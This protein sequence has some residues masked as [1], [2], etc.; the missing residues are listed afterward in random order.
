MN[1]VDNYLLQVEG[2]KKYFL[3]Y[4]QE[5]IIRK[6]NLEA[7]ENYLYPE[8]LGRS[9]RIHRHSGMVERLEEKW[10]ETNAHGEVMTLL[11]LVCDSRED[12]FP[13][14]RWQAM[15]NFGSMFHRSLLEERED[16]FARA[17]QENPQGFCRACEALGGEPGPSGDISY[18]LE[19]FDGLKVLAQFWEEDEDFPPQVRWMWDAN[20]LMYLKYETMWYALGMLQREILLRM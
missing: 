3:R 18:T 9:Y 10:V 19:I 15:S 16:P 1:H 17:I 11:D 20:A 5:K 12:R 14:G 4:D 2:A 6:L 8:M 13:A 7:D